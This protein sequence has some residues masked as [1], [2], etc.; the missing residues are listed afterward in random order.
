MQFLPGRK[1]STHQ[2]CRE[3]SETGKLILSFSPPSFP[4]TDADMEISA[5]SA[6]R[7]CRIEFFPAWPT[8]AVVLGSSDTRVYFI[9]PRSALIPRYACMAHASLYM[10]SCSA[11]YL[12]HTF[13]L[14]SVGTVLLHSGRKDVIGTN[15][16]HCCRFPLIWRTGPHRRIPTSRDRIIL[17]RLAGRG[18]GELQ[19]RRWR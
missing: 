4:P 17:T 12:L 19:Q 16:S 8:W 1:A 7:F 14:L 18:T 2:F 11:L 10:S 6:T 9:L 15:V 5:T 3:L 13:Y